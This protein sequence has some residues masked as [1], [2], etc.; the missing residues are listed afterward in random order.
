MSFLFQKF[1]VL[2]FVSFSK[3]FLPLCNLL[4]WPTAFQMIWN[5]NS[6]CRKTQFYGLCF[7]CRNNNDLHRICVLSFGLSGAL[8]NVPQTCTNFFGDASIQIVWSCINNLLL[9]SDIP[10]FKSVYCSWCFFLPFLTNAYCTVCSTAFDHTLTLFFCL[11]VL[12]IYFFQTI[13]LFV[14]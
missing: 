5:I 9:W 10:V 3:F 4:T 2:R 7:M 6:M 12:I 14:P 1:D 13:W 8:H 11:D